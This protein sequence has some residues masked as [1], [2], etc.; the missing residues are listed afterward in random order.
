MTVIKDLL[1]QVTAG[2]NAAL[3]IYDTCTF[4]YAKPKCSVTNII[5]FMFHAKKKNCALVKFRDDL[6]FIPNVHHIIYLLYI[7]FMLI[8]FIATRNLRHHVNYKHLLLSCIFE[9]SCE[10]SAKQDT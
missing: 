6:L 3:G 2:Y 7:N 5:M 4:N 1:L 9:F 8:I 10:T